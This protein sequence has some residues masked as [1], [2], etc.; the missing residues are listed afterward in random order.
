MGLHDPFG[1]PQHKLWW[2][3]RL[4]VKLAIW[5]PTTKSRESTWLPCVQVVC[6]MPLERS[7]QKLQLY[8]KLH[9]DW[10]FEH[11]IIAPQSCESSN[12]GSFR[13]P[14]WESQDKKPFGC[15]PRRKVQNILY[16][17]RWWLPLSPGHGESCEFEVACGLSSHQRCPNIILTN[18]WLVGCRFVWVNKLLVTFPSPIPKLQHV[19]LPP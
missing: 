4:E 2:K 10:R 1:H 14:T 17:G 11:E 9:P 18:L 7:P 8:F 19:P 5:V 13:T 16:G 6:D 3:E 15:G 12:L